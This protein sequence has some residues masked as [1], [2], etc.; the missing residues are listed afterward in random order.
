MVP[1]SQ[2]QE[3]QDP[4]LS[5]SY[6]KPLKTLMIANIN[7]IPSMILLRSYVL[8]SI[9]SRYYKNQEC[10]RFIDPFYPYHNSS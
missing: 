4:I 5:A 6:D 8:K 3:E 9:V 2:L 7:S 10:L 1:L